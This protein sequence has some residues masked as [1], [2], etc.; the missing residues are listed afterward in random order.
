M[1]PR[2]FLLKALLV[3]ALVAGSFLSLFSENQRDF[4][5]GHCVDNTFKTTDSTGGT[6]G[7]G[8][9]IIFPIGH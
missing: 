7:D 5:S 1:N 6:S 9:P 2:H 3:S 8:G 4:S